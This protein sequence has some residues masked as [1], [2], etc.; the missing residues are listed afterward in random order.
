[1]KSWNPTEAKAGNSNATL[2]LVAN[3]TIP[4]TT[5]QR[6]YELAWENRIKPVNERK[7]KVGY[8]R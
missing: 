3:G 1:M 7:L 2:F 5:S 8:G 4:A 6:L